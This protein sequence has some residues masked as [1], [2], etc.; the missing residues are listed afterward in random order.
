[1]VIFHSYVSLPEGKLAGKSLIIHCRISPEIWSKERCPERSF[2][3]NETQVG[4]FLKWYPE[5]I[6][7]NRIVHY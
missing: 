1:M 3:A 2:D 7:S 5:I 6:H 4:G